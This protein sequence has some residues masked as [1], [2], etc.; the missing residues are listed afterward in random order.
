[1]TYEFE[2]VIDRKSK[3]LPLRRPPPRVAG[4]A[5]FPI[6]IAADTSLKYQVGIF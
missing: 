3:Q 5:D 1:M 4:E 6:Q 2:A